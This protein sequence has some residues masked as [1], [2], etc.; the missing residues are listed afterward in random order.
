MKKIEN[1]IHGKHT[2][3]SNEELKVFNPSTGEQSGKVVLSN[4][5]DFQK[6]IESSKKNLLDWAN[7]TPLKRSRI[8]SK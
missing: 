2:S 7:T 8:I 6:T 3:S 1:Y 5:E 4:Y